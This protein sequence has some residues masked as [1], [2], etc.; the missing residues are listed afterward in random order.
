MIID[1]FNGHLHVQAGE[2]IITGTI[3]VFL[4]GQWSK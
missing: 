2:T 3:A 1:Y 4:H